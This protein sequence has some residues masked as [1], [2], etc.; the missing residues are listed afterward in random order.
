MAD[1]IP[2]IEG[3]AHITAFTTIM[4]ETTDPLAGGFLCR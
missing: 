3:V 2:E 1:G 4:K